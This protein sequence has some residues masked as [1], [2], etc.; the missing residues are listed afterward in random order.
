MTRA[1]VPA[2]AGLQALVDTE[3]LRRWM[4]QRGI[5]HGELT[6]C[7]LLAGGTQNIL[8]R[9]ERGGQ[10]YVLRRPPA[11]PRPESNAAMLREARV[12]GALAG[13]GVPH[14][15]LVAACDDTEVLGTAFFLMRAV[16]GF[17]A[18]TSGLPALHASRR[19]M[20]RRMGLAM[21]EA[22][23]TLGSLDPDAL[24]LQDF[25][26]PQGF[27]QRQVD[28]W[29]RQLDS[30]AQHAAWPGPAGLPAIAPIA[31]WLRSH[32]P[33]DTAP[34]ILHGDFHLSN[35]MFRHDSAEL[36]AVVDWEMSTVGDPLVDLGTLLATW[37]RPDGAHH[38]T[39]NIAPWEGFALEHELVAHYALHSPRDLSALRWYAV[40]ACYKLAVV[41]EGTHA[42]A[43]AGLAPAATG[44][45]LHQAACG[46]LLRAT[47]WIER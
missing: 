5:G 40:L 33:A 42:R 17:N 23:A 41:L 4:D 3:R 45:R 11:H 26:R 36:A 13:S 39:N 18:G 12:L 28:R 7:Q 34:G 19:D 16:E 47:E 8:L 21:A 29:G 46:L 37:P 14:A 25:G 2:S 31:Q 20:R 44:D 1:A 6:R 15:G 35:V 24:G 38:I 27:L 32:Q 43:C 30:Y 10:C 9:F 22:A